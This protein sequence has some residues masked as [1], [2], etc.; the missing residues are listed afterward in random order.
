LNKGIF[1]IKE[2][3]PAIV[4]A[5]TLQLVHHKATTHN[6]QPKITAIYE[7]RFGTLVQGNT[8]Y[9]IF[10][11]ILPAQEQCS[12]YVTETTFICFCG[13]HPAVQT[14]RI[15]SYT[16]N[17]FNQETYNLKHRIELDIYAT[18]QISTVRYDS[19]YTPSPLKDISTKVLYDVDYK[20][21]HIYILKRL[22]LSYESLVLEIV[23]TTTQWNQYQYTTQAELC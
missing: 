10:K 16:V 7:Q 17:N 21:I 4:N 19:Y 23:I 5:T 20:L 11:K 14:Y 8:N 18:W 15:G 12:T 9:L 6:L 2:T 22:Y 13:G 1:N 3:G